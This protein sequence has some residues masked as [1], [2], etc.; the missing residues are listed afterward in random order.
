[1]LLLCPDMLKTNCS[2]TQ[3]FKEELWKNHSWLTFSPTEC[4][5]KSANYKVGALEQKVGNI[6]QFIFL[7]KKPN[8]EHK[9]L[10]AAIK[11]QRNPCFS[12]WKPMVPLIKS[13]KTSVESY[14]RAL[15]SVGSMI[16]N[17]CRVIVLAQQGM[18][19]ASKNVPLLR[20][21]E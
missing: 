15:E 1:M 17:H 19:W 8:L 21:W 5:V 11:L 3:S 2:V 18:Y 6:L 13:D 14:L 4:C 16:F 9:S 10:S 7:W 20:H 12:V